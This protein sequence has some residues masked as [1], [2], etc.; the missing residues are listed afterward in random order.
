MFTERNNLL[1]ER[2]GD[3]VPIPIADGLPDESVPGDRAAP[4]TPRF[5]MSWRITWSIVGMC[6]VLVGIVVLFLMR[7]GVPA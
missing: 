6:L 3:S 4:S 5:E 2:E 1:C 7:M